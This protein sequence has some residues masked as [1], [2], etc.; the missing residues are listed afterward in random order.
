MKNTFNR[1]IFFEKIGKAALIISVAS[2]IPIKVFGTKKKYVNEK[3]KINIHP[4]A[5]KRSSKV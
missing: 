4:S 1:K 3:I 5:V 2:A